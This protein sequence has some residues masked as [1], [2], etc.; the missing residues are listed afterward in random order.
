MLGRH[1][2]KRISDKG[3]I[4]EF[5]NN[6]RYDEYYKN[7]GV[8]KLAHEIQERQNISCKINS[9]F[10]DDYITPITDDDLKDEKFITIK[11][12]KIIDGKRIEYTPPPRTIEQII[13]DDKKFYLRLIE[14]FAEQT[15]VEYPKLGKILNSKKPMEIFPRFLFDCRPYI[16]PLKEATDDR[17][18]RAKYALREN[19]DDY[20]EYPAI[21]INLDFSDDAIIADVKKHLIQLRKQL[22]HKP[23]LLP[24]KEY[25]RKFKN[26]R[27]LQVIDIL[28]WQK[29]TD[30]HIE[31]ETL[32]E[33]LF[34]QGQFTGKQL[35]ET[36]I[37]FTK[38]LLDSK[39]NESAYMFYLADKK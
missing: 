12:F 16:Q 1:E 37:P 33:F 32:A 31:Y 4:P 24:P 28:L 2:L 30:H 35:R 8:V 22:K 6:K 38:K 39:S 20:D 18:I 34:P 5:F 21:S 7:C 23:K 14:G 17:E 9:I 15:Y 11:R 25:L 26:F 36:I 10:E 29:L 27:A 13:E 19:V 3:K